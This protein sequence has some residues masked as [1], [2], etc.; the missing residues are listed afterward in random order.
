MLNP[1]LRW[2]NVY[3]RLKDRLSIQRA[4]AGLQP[5][6]HNMLEA[7][8][9]EPGFAH[10]SPYDKTQFLKMWLDLIPGG[11]GN[12]VLRQHYE[13]PLRML[14]GVTG[15]VL[16]IAC[17]NLASLLAARAAARQKEIAV[18]L[19][20]GSGR[21]RII[22]QLMTESLMLA[23]VGGVAGIGLATVMVKSLLGFLPANTGGYTLS[24]TP[25]LRIFGFSM[26]LSLLT[27]IAF[28]LVPALQASFH[29]QPRQPALRKSGIYHQ[30][31]RTV[32]SGRW[33]NRL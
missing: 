23:L 29:S 7:E 17:A 12:S 9:R 24:S 20:I 25:D 26:A 8:V 2:L 33:F 10:A 30:Q 3:G 28:G 16:L 21:T 31:S 1:R 15:F 14:L 4:K 32:R 18:R 11:Q 13:R 27:G 19:A 6:F 5:L 22:R